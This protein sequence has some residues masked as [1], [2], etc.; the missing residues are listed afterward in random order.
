M[1]DADKHQGNL[2]VL[3]PIAFSFIR[4]YLPWLEDRVGR[5]YDA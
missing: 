4:D 1:H 3:C 2:T 5:S